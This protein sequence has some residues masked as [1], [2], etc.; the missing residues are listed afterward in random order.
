M[1]F[2][3][4]ENDCYNRDL[5]IAQKLSSR[6][7]LFPLS[8]PFSSFLV[9][10][11]IFKFHLIAFI[12][13]NEV[14]RSIAFRFTKYSKNKWLP[15]GVAQTVRTINT[16]GYDRHSF[17]ITY[18][19]RSVRA[20]RFAR[21][22]FETRKLPL[23]L[24]SYANHKSPLP[25][26][27]ASATNVALSMFVVVLKHSLRWTSLTIRA[28]KRTSECALPYREFRCRCWKDIKKCG[29]NFGFLARFDVFSWFLKYKFKKFDV[30]DIFARWLF[31]KSACRISEAYP[32]SGG[33]R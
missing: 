26:N 30:I 15:F 20:N 7:R 33:S 9:D 31:A 24:R 17:K 2:P 5:L 32:I 18:G 29:K 19:T 16:F 13:I 4:V 12:A 6:L 14:T 8:Q 22:D 23:F 11:F 3:I 10:S 28:V 21:K 1:S 25:R 27:I